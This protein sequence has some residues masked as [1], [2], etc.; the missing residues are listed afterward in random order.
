MTPRASLRLVP[1]MDGCARHSWRWRRMR[2]RG[3]VGRGTVGRS[4]ESVGR[5]DARES[6]RISPERRRPVRTTD[7]PTT[8]D[9]ARARIRRHC[10]GCRAHSTPLPWMPRASIPVAGR[11]DARGVITHRSETEEHSHRAHHQNQI[12]SQITQI[13]SSIITRTRRTHVPCRHPPHRRVMT[14]HTPTHT[15]A[16]Q[17][18]KSFSST[19]NALDPT[20][21]TRRDDISR[22]T[23]ISSHHE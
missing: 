5:L 3:V 2:A 16:R 10:R 9:A 7:R 19:R 18:S 13:K 17:P 21:A 20:A 14:R 22:R 8:D 6:A 23:R 11:R 4:L 12:K 1:G 15:P